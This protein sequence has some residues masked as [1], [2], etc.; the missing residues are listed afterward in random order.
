MSLYLIRADNKKGINISM[1]LKEGTEPVY[2]VTL[3]KYADNNGKG[4]KKE[5]Y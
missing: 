4:G 5:G 3:N 2:S 1:L